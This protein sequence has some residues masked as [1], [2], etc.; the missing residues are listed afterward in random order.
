MLILDINAIYS[1]VPACHIRAD[2]V[3]HSMIMKKGKSLRIVEFYAN[4]PFYKHFNKIQHGA[5]RV[6]LELQKNK[7]I[8]S[9]NGRQY[10]YY[11]KE[12]G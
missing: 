4:L 2:E 3:H 1:F 6:T 7:H 8:N 5:V 9:K 12:L 11:S 10:K